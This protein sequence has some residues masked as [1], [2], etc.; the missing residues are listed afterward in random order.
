[1]KVATL[2]F[3]RTLHCHLRTEKIS[4]GSSIFMSSLTLTWHERRTPSRASPR[5]IWLVSVGS[6]APPPSS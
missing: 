4:A 2:W 1:M 3:E 5:L 6:M